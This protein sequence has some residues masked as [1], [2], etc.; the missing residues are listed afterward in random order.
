MPALF[1]SEPGQGP[2]VA[3]HGF[4]RRHPWVRLTTDP[5]FVHHDRAAP[6]RRV[7]LVSGGGSGHEPMHVGFVGTGMLDAA[8]PGKIFA[9]PHNRQVYEASKAVA[10]DGG[11]L[12]I[13]KNYT[14]D[15]INFGIAAERLAADGI[16]ADRVLV[17]DDVATESDETA[18]GRRGTAATII[19]EKILGAAADRGDSLSSL[20]ALGREVTAHSRSIAV[21][22]QALTS[23]NS[24][25][26]AFELAPDQLEYG[27]GIHGE[28]ASTSIARPPLEELVDRMLTDILAALPGA[29][30]K[31][32]LLLVNGLGATTELEL[33]AI[34]ELAART[35]TARGHDIAAVQVGTFVS[36]LDMSGF[37]ITLTQLADGWLDLW[38][39]PTTAPAW[40]DTTR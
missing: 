26:R 25:A 39:A 2:E 29:D 6:T 22:T 1:L 5:L 33:C 13:V 16:E 30:R 20:T 12:H 10:R 37:S 34:V 19:V 18:T 40:K 23:P 15:K 24:G 27:V 38:H 9:S 11:V 28:R 35:L 14:G 3:L 36:A 17:D 4:A 21:A 31:P 8:V 7:A 32:L